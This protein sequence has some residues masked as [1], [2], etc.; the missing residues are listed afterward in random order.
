MNAELKPGVDII[1]EAIKLEKHIIDADFVI[2][3]EGRIDFQSIMGKAPT[4]VSKLC[5]K[6]NVPVIAIAGSVSDDASSTHDYG[7]GAIFSI[8]NAPIS[9][10]EAM[11]EENSKKL[12]EKNTEDYNKEVFSRTIDKM[13]ANIE[14]LAESWKKI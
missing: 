8:M 11:N 4:G 7:I 5:K 6:H 13:V 12:V 9:L 2:T 14:E 1:L 10:E 3:G